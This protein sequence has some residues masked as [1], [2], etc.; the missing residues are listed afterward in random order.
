MFLVD[1]ALVPKVSTG[2]EHPAAVLLTSSNRHPFIPQSHLL[3]VARSNM[4]RRGMWIILN[5]GRN[6]PVFKFLR[7]LIKTQRIAFTARGG[8]LRAN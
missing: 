2:D 4:I 1:F 6:Q 7:V 5:L 8:D 3:L